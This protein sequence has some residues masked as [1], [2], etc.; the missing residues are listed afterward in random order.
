MALE[1][2]PLHRR[3]AI[4]RTD[5]AITPRAEPRFDVDVDR[6]TPT[7]DQLQLLRGADIRDAPG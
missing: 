4:H 3:R 6:I 1:S 5:G 7:S 2:P